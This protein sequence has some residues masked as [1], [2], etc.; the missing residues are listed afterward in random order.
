ML[1]EKG[2]FG[3]RNVRREGGIWSENVRRERGYLE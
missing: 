2:V 3:V 1:G